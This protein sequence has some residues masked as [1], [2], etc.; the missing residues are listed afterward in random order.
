MRQKVQDVLRKWLKIDFYDIAHKI[1]FINSSMEEVDDSLINDTV[2]CL[3]YLSAMK[4]EN[5]NMNYVI[6]L[7]SLMW[8]HIDHKK[9]DMRSFVIKILSRIGY[10]TSAIIADSHFDKDNCLFA[11]LNSIIDQ[12]T[13]GINQSY[14][15]VKVNNKYF[16][17]T[18]FQ[19]KFGM[20]WM[21]N[22][23]SEYLHRHQRANHLLLL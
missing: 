1:G 12:I 2:R 10:P 20:Q 17:L 14:N 23:C 4:I 15:Q 13:V 8:V 9:Y 5:E 3:D 16:L 18:A 22:M 19:K 6:T 11:P 21:K 7:I